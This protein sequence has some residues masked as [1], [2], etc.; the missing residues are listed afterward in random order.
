MTKIMAIPQKK[1][2]LFFKRKWSSTRLKNDFCFR[3]SKNF[4]ACYNTIFTMNLLYSVPSLALIMLSIV[5]S[6]VILQSNKKINKIQTNFEAEGEVLV[7]PEILMVKIIETKNC[8]KSVLA[9]WLRVNFRISKLE[10][11]L[12]KYS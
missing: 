11:Y 3:F 7:L 2:S 5:V 8:S 12:S 6:Y 1:N 4:N 10:R 9:A